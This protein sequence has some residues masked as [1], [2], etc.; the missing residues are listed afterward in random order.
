M[1]SCKYRV[2][3]SIDGGGKKG[4]I[5]LRVLSFLEEQLNMFVERSHLSSW[6][7][8]YAGTSTSAIIAGALAVSGV[9]GRDH[10]PSE[11]TE[12]YLR[13][14]KH[15][16]DPQ[17]SSHSVHPLNYVLEHFYGDLTLGQIRKHF[18]FV[19]YDLDRD[20]PF[21][22]S[23]SQHHIQQIAISKMMQACCA[24]PGFLDAVRI[25]NK[26]LADGMLTAK[27]PSKLAFQYARVFY[28]DDPIVLVS[29]GTGMSREL[30]FEEIQAE[31]QHRMLMDM[32]RNDSGLVYFRFNPELSAPE[33]EMEELLQMTDQYIHDNMPSFER[34]L[35]LMEIKA[36]RLL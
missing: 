5:P 8:V 13:R 21:L 6:V 16:F 28:P 18:L 33:V 15:F 23:D 27:N 31:E 35:H 20:E 1:S 25:G 10:Y 32:A 12:L 11:M 29:I 22:F 19:S 34:L 4:L 36:G 9:N 7:D 14:G 26:R 3:V 17:R 2:V 24:S 30:T